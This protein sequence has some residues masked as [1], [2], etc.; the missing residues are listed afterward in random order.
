MARH[1]NCGSDRL[2]AHATLIGG[3]KSR[4]LGKQLR[5]RS[6]N[7]NDY[8]RRHIDE[9]VWYNH[10]TGADGVKIAVLRKVRASLRFIW[11]AAHARRYAAIEII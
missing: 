8:L 1:T 3:L 2:F 11:A 10:A 5:I 9:K 4:N 7:W 6:V